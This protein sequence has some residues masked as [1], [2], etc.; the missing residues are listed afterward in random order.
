MD[1]SDNNLGCPC[2]MCA[3]SLQGDGVECMWNDYIPSEDSM[4]Y[5][6][7]PKIEFERIQQLQSDGY[8]E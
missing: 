5:V 7:N 1:F 3:G 2:D 6:T 8:I 4:R